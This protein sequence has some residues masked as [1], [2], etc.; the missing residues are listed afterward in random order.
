M[1][2]S[3]KELNK[4]ERKQD[5]SRKSIFNANTRNQTTEDGFSGTVFALSWVK[6]SKTW[7]TA[8]KGMTGAALSLDETNVDF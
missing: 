8:V 1:F 2:A 7:A 5:F 6:S 4:P 3:A